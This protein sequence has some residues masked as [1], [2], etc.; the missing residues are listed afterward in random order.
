M[1]EQARI[2]NAGIALTV[3]E[4]SSGDYRQRIISIGSNN[5]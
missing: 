2:N 1:D 5:G 3:I 4:H